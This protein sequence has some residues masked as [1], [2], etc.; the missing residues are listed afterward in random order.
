VAAVSPQKKPATK[1]RVRRFLLRATADPREPHIAAM[2]A[3]AKSKNIKFVGSSEPMRNLR[4]VVG[5]RLPDP[6]TVGTR[7]ASSL[8]VRDQS[9]REAL[10]TR[11]HEAGDEFAA[12]QP[13]WRS[14]SWHGQP[15]STN[16]EG[17]S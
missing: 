14:G 7:P 4:A 12:F 13:F 3:T 1:L 2:M 16:E 9:E 5:G 15:F 17:S 10:A 6:T 8:I 11:C